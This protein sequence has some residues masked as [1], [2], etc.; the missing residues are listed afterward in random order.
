MEARRALMKQK[1]A[2]DVFLGNKNTQIFLIGRL[3]YPSLTCWLDGSRG[4]LTI[5]RKML[6][7]LL[8]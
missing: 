4:N 5:H 3:L 6:I 7:P 8:Q 1:S 2:D